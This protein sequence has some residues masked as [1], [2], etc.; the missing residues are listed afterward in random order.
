MIFATLPFYSATVYYP[1][2]FT[3]QMLMQVAISDIYSCSTPLG[4]T[5]TVTL[6][7]ID[8]NAGESAKVR[9]SFYVV[10]KLNSHHVKCN[11]NNR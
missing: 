4:I 3:R 11:S 6:V 10:F 9:P 7:V 1:L 2:Y 5:V 8:Y